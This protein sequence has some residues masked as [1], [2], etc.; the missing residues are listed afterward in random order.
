MFIDARHSYDAVLEDL[1]AWW[2]KI[3][4]GG[5]LAGHDYVDADE[6]WRCVLQPLAEAQS[7]A[8][9]GPDDGLHLRLDDSAAGLVEAWASGAVSWEQL[10]E[11]TSLDHG[12]LIR[13]LRRTLDVLRTTASLDAA[14]LPSE[15]APVRDVARRAAAAI[16]RP[17]V[18]D[19]TYDAI[20]VP[21][22]EYVESE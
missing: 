8:G 19:T 11:S 10:S 17:P 21:D 12:D 13:L 14:I 2:P 1:N 4:P 9:L 18:H 16:D 3:R 5:I 20:F 22:D 7:D 6:L 15:F